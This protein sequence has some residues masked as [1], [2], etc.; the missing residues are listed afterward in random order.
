MAEK[1]SEAGGRG[2]AACRVTTRCLIGRKKE[3]KGNEIK[4]VGE[5][6]G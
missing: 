5:M 3:I 6:G 1:T 2:G 4:R